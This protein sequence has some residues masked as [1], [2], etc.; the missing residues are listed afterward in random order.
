MTEPGDVDARALARELVGEVRG[1]IRF[2]P[3]S[4]AL[5]AN[6]ASVYRQVPIGVVVPRSAAD[7]VATLEICRRHGAPIGARLTILSRATQG[8]EVQL[9]I[10]FGDQAGTSRSFLSGKPTGI[11]K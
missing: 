3:G 1:E 10:S 9:S 6:D 2:S 7:V 11:A 4:R 8:T 5:Y